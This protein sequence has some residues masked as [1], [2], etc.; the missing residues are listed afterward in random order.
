MAGSVAAAPMLR[1]KRL[2]A[3][4]IGCRMRGAGKQEPTRSREIVMTELSAL[5]LPIL[6]GAVVLLHRQFH[7]SHDAAVAQERIPAAAR[8]RAGA[9]R[10]RRAQRAARRLHAAA[11]QEHEGDGLGGFQGEAAA[12]TEL[13][14]HRAAAGRQRHGGRACSSGSC[15]SCWCCVFAALRVEPCARARRALPRGVP[16]RRRDRVHGLRARRSCRSPSG[17]AARGARRSS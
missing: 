14:H 1:R 9:R 15:S 10:H 6:L 12:G 7:H 8:R 4:K 3:L 11:L 17:I 13:D 16:L 5:W 2:F